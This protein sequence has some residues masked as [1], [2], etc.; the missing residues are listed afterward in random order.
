MIKIIYLDSGEVMNINKSSQNHLMDFNS[1]HYLIFGWVFSSNYIIWN[2][3]VE[4]S[5]IK[6]Y[7]QDTHPTNILAISRLIEYQRCSKINRIIK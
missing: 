5:R 7:Y 1:P 2:D 4:V 6:E 3:Y